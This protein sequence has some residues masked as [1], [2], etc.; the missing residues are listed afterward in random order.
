[1]TNSESPP[2]DRWLR[3]A[4]ALKKNLL[5]RRLKSKAKAHVQDKSHLSKET[6]S[7]GK[8]DVNFQSD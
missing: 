5:K 7:S 2:S 6:V 4:E 8:K 3:S 1:M